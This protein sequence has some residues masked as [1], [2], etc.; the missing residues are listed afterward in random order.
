MGKDFARDDLKAFTLV[1]IMI[2]ISVLVLLASIAI[3]NLLRARLT[4]NDT[5]AQATLKTISNACESY[6]AANFGSYPTDITDLTDANPSYLNENYTD[7]N[8]R[9]GYNFSCDTLDESGYSCTATS[10][11]CNHT[12]SK[13]YTITTGGILTSVDCS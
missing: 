2:A 6:G 4:A 3:P 9:Y 1:E 13:V 8:V 11:V 5:A 10:Q 12:G 7:G